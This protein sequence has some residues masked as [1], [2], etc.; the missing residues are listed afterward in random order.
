MSDEES[1]E[2]Q[3]RGRCAE[4][5]RFFLKQEYGT[6]CLQKYL[7]IRVVIYLTTMIVVRM[8]EYNE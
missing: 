5:G 8:N 3:F 6:L 2:R 1:A 7:R 4:D